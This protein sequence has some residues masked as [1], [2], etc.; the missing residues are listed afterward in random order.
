MRRT[1]LSRVSTQGLR[2]MFLHKY[3]KTD[4]HAQVGAPTTKAWNTNGIEAVLF[5]AP[6]IWTLSSA[7]SFGKLCQIGVVKSWRP[8]LSFRTVVKFQQHSYCIP[9][10]WCGSSELSADRKSHSRRYM[11]RLHSFGKNYQGLT[12]CVRSLGGFDFPTSSVS[13]LTRFWSKKH[14]YQ[15]FARRKKKMWWKPRWSWLSIYTGGITRDMG[16]PST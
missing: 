8:V 16:I 3:T 5:L 9:S 11:G 2:Y 6:Y 12:A 13:P 7:S 4:A 1:R 15:P 10:S 14:I